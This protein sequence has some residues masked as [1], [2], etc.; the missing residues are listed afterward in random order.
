M[1]KDEAIYEKA[2]QVAKNKVSFIRNFIMYI[3]VLAVLAAINNLTFGGYQWWLWVALFWGIGL[4]FNFLKA[5]IFRG[6]GL[7]RLEERLTKQEIER[8]GD[9]E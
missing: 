8:M 4:I 2:R 7:E 6:S 5:F 1:S 3:V 9:E